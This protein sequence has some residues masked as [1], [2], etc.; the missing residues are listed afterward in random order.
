MSHP[1]I[2][3]QSWTFINSSIN[4]HDRTNS[5]KA[6]IDSSYRLPSWWHHFPARH[7][8]V[9]SGLGSGCLQVL[10]RSRQNAAL[11]VAWQIREGFRSLKISDIPYQSG[12]P[13]FN[14]VLVE[15]WNWGVLYFTF[16]LIWWKFTYFVQ[17]RINRAKEPLAAARFPKLLRSSRWESI[18]KN[19]IYGTSTRNEC[20]ILRNS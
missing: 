1:V 13:I 17:G 19:A 12:F 2:I 5:K 11:H 16:K 18:K 8:D 7:C 4:C 6:R 10:R 15:W 3:S 20:G 9:Q 14:G